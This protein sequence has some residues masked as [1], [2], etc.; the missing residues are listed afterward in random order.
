MVSNHYILSSIISVCLSND[1]LHTQY[2]IVFGL[3]V[4]CV[5]SRSN[6][7]GKIQKNNRNLQAK[8]IEKYTRISTL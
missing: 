5:G 1:T 6:V 4:S 2:M 8:K 7:F 3:S